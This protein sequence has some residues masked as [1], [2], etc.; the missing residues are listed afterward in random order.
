M[1]DEKPVDCCNRNEGK[2]NLRD[3]PRIVMNEVETR[4][5]RQAARFFVLVSQQRAGT[6]T[7]IRL[8]APAVPFTTI[9]CGVLPSLSADN[10]PWSTDDD[11]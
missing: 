2:L 7:H 10:H 1:N 6:H 4:R 5:N 3:N 8:V 9:S 11:E